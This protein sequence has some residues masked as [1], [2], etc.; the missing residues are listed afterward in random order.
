[1]VVLHKSSELSYPGTRGKWYAAD[2]FY[3]LMV[4][5]MI[6]S[7]VF[8]TKP[9]LYGDG[10]LLNSESPADFLGYF[11]LF[12]AGT[13][14]RT[15][16]YRKKLIVVLLIVEIAHG[17]LAFFQTFD[18]QITYCLL[19]RHSGAAY[20]LTP[21]SNFYGG[22]SVFILAL[23]SGVY[24]FSEAGQDLSGRVLW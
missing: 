12:Y 16:E 6:L 4:I 11:C 13:R 21:N 10:Y 5:F 17:V 19:T 7:A 2:V 8:S 20:G 23:V 18:I 3:L 15:R 1:M 9:G 14:I 24:L 22:L